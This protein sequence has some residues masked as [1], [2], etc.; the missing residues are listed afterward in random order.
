MIPRHLARAGLLLLAAAVVLPALASA[1]GLDEYDVARLEMVS[2]AAISPDGTTIAYTLSVP[3]NP[4]EHDNGPAFSELYVVDAKGGTPRGYVTGEVS[5]GKLSFTPDGRHI[6]FTTKRD[7]DDHTSLYTIPVDGG[8]ARKLLAFGSSI[9]GYSFAPDGRHVAFLAKEPKDE[10]LEEL[11]EKGFNAKVYE[12]AVPFVQLHVAS[13]DLA[14][15]TSGE[16]RHLDVP[17]SASELHWSPAGDRLAVALATTPLIDDHYVTRRFHFVSPD[18][19]AVLG[20]IS[21]EGKLGDLRFSPDGKHVA[22]VGPAHIN[23]PDAGRL[24]VASSE[25]GTPTDLLPGLLGHV[26]NIAWLDDDTVLHVAGVGV[27]TPVGTVD[28]DGGN[29]KT[30]V[31]Q[32]PIL[33][34]VAVGQGR[35]ALVGSTPMHPNELFTMRA[36]ATAP[37]RVTD[38]NP[39]L[40]DRELAK[41]EPATYVARDGLELEGVLIHPLQRDAG[42]R[43]PMVLTVHG[44]PEAHRS[45]GWLSYYSRP[46]Q[47]AAARGWAVFFP[48]YRG[49]TGRGVEFSMLSQGD[50]AGKE[51]DDL[52]DAV[53]HF[54]DE[55]LVDEDKVGI[56]GGSYGGYASAWGATALSEHFAASVMSV[57]ISNQISKFG[58]TDIANEMYH[59]HQRKWMWDGHWQ[60]YLE[61]SPIYHAANQKTPLLIMHGEEDPRVHPGQSLELY[62]NVL[63]RGQAPVR[64]VLWPG[65]GHGNRKAAARLEY[66]LRMM[67]WFDSYLEGDADTPKP[68]VEIEID[69]SRLA[70]E[71]PASATEGGAAR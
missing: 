17:G 8:E 23:D 1:R 19:G 59:V 53:R 66:S 6:A 56:T 25:G 68:P 51:F 14:A 60:F 38:S 54:V 20:V 55:G 43:V 30:L 18:D 71:E 57:G 39:W 58:T 44:G 33:G 22:F 26:E 42:E 69:E 65:E 27:W 9:S 41:Q 10:A 40:A 16:P 37:T 45:N 2:S 35:V 11:Q 52:V 15:G 70:G 64:L 46:S 7:G 31:E 24:Y 50:P 36:R 21:T 12:E 13:V 29:A 63:H 34:S 3:R 48:N 4:F 61:R 49:S 32:G 47:V 62:R 5:V 28:I 67:R